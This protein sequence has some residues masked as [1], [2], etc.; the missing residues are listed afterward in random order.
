MYSISCSL[1]AKLPRL[2]S[3]IIFGGIPV[4]VKAIRREQYRYVIMAV[5]V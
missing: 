5:K 4:I 3:A 2:G 1:S